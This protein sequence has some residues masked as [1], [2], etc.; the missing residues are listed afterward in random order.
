LAKNQKERNIERAT[1][2]WII[3]SHILQTKRWF[4]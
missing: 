3:F 4:S 1:E 2:R